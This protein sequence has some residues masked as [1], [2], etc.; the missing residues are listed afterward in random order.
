MPGAD[1]A[2]LL[3]AAAEGGRIALH[4]WKRGPRVWDKGAEGPVSEADLAVNRMLAEELR[5][6]RPGYGWLSEEGP[7]DPARLGCGRCLIVDPIDGTRAFLAG[8][9]AFAVALAVAEAGAVTAAVIHL[10]ALGLTYAAE[11]GGPATCN[12]AVLRASVRARPEGAALLAPRAALAPEHW[13]G[14]VPPVRRVFRAS[15]AY[16]MAR[17]AEGAEDAML[18]IG[19]T[20][21]WDAAAGALIAAQAGALVTGS[22]GEALG[23]NTAGARVPGL[24]AANPALHAQLLGRRQPPAAAAT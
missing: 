9:S 7:D 2:L 21:E 20:W 16:R 11:A 4:H 17:V 8:E 22:R 18:A 13:P 15:L 3:A 24:L 1:L 5:A 14:G 10:P 19:P 6:A 12:G 23:F